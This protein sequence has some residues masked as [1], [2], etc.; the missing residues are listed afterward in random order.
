MVWNSR[1]GA[2]LLAVCVAYLAPLAAY[3][4]ELYF[5]VDSFAGVNFAATTYNYPASGSG[6]NYDAVGDMAEADSSPNLM[7]SATR[8]KARPAP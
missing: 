7:G 3:G 2:A 5:R 8:P 4:A 6:V 1:T